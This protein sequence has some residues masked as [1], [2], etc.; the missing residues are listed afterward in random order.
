LN[1]FIKWTLLRWHFYSLKV[2]LYS[3]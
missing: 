3:N 2:N 1:Y